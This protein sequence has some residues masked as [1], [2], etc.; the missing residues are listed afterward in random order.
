MSRCIIESLGE[1][2]YFYLSFFL[3][4]DFNVLLTYCKLLR[5]D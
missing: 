1:S 3:A 2:N 5:D 4:V